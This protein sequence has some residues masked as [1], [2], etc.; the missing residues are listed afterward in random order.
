VQGSEHSLTVAAQDAES[1]LAEDGD[2]SGSVPLVTTTLGQNEAVVTAVDRVGHET[3]DTCEYEV[4]ASEE[5]N[6]EEPGGEEPGGEEPNNGGQTPGGGG[7]QT[8]TGAQGPPAPQTPLSPGAPAD[9]AA[10][11][12]SNLRAAEKCLRNA[13]LGR[14][15]RGRRDIAFR[16]DLSDAATVT[17]SI[18]RR[19]S[20]RRA[21]T[22]CPG[23]RR[24]SKGE[25]TPDTYTEVGS[26]Q[27][28]GAT[29]GNR[30]RVGAHQAR[31][32]TRRFVG[33]VQAGTN[34][35]NLSALASTHRLAPGLYRLVAVAEDAAGNRSAPVIVKFW[36][37]GR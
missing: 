23:A 22:R 26:Q 5:P 37:L 16:Y 11:V 9:D 18:Q 35:L 24:K 13:R 19:E 2:P 10:P 29:G 30:N 28:N 1:G 32:R 4:V 15:A 20:T 3:S 36:V 17:L 21:R 25:G 14:R 34:R 6:E 33:D 31:S 27:E 8:P 7:G 12:I